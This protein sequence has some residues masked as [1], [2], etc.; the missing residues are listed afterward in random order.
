MANQKHKILVVDDLADWRT[1]LKG[2][3][4]DEGF[5]VQEAESFNQALHL[6]TDDNFDLVIADLR[7]DDSDDSN[8]E[9]LDLANRVKEHW[10]DTKVILITGYDTKVTVE[11]ALQPDSQGR[12]LAVDYIAKNQTNELPELAH[13]F[14]S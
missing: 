3:L 7:L 6:L 11:Q 1:T 10:P 8:T 4:I 12:S 2:M 5:D 9:G 14:L 13:K